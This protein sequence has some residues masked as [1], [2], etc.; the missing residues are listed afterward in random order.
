MTSNL[1]AG[2]PVST[3]T[4]IVGLVTV[5]AIQ[6]AQVV[7]AIKETPYLG[8]AFLALTIACVV[9]AGALFVNEQ[10]IVWWSV[11]AVNS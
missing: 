8:G 4:V 10:G 6:W 1:R 3:T 9:L 7:P 5:A 11:A 2:D